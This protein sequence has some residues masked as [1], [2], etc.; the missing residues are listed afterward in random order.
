MVGSKFLFTTFFLL[1]FFF[2]PPTPAA[3][4][5]EPPYARGQV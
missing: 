5:E 1:L 2:F 4:L 3:D